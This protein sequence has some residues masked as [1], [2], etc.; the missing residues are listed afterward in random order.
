VSGAAKYRAIRDILLDRI[1]SGA[2]PPGTPIP[3]E[4]AL[5]EE[6]GVTRPTVSRALSALVEGGLVE[7]RRRAGSRVADRPPAQSILRIPLVREEIER[8]GARYGYR[9]IERALAPPPEAIAALFGSASR[10]ALHLRCLHLADGEGHQIEDRWINLAA[11]PEAGEEDFAVTSANEWLVARVPF[12]R[13]EHVMSAASAG[14][15]EARLL[16]L[17]PGAPLFLIERTTWRGEEALTRVRLAHP[18]GRFRIVARSF[19]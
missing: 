1:A 14:R 4:A 5:A 17:A 7:R 11:L 19:L 15:E 9:L 18:G 10:A 12:S 2:W 3:H 13:A 8:A 16:G 6:F